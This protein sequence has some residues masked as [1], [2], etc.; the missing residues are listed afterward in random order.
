MEVP[1]FDRVEAYHP[2]WHGFLRI[3]NI[4][5]SVLHE[6]HQNQGTY[7]LAGRTLTVFW[8]NY[9]P[10]VFIACSGI[11]IHKTLIDKMTEIEGLHFV[12]VNKSPI[13]LSRLCVLVPGTRHE[14]S[15]RVGTSDVATFIQVLVNREFESPNLP[16][17]ANAIVDLGANIGLATVFFGI[18]YPGARILAVEPEDNNYAITV[19]NVS[20]L[21]D[22]VHTR[23]AAV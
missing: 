5:D 2:N 6:T 15:L 12:S 8:K 21:G 1:T 18:K 19:A 23:N 7:E 11:Y 17:T 22:R 20:A 16:V 10:D 3:S 13:V 14:V 9:D 4:N